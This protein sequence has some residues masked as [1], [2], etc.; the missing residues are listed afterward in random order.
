MSQ[1]H[2]TC[3]QCSDWLTWR[4]LNAL[5]GCS[6]CSIL[7]HV[8]CVARSHITITSYLWYSKIGSLP[9][10][11]FTSSGNCIARL[12][13]HFIIYGPALRI[14]KLRHSSYYCR[15]LL[16]SWV[17]WFIY[18]SYLVTV[19]TVIAQSVEHRTANSRPVIDSRPCRRTFNF[20]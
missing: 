2:V 13:E 19:H 4:A 20:F 12:A 7:Y 14:S 11:K 9:N 6:V 15:Y 3:T 1:H 16:N 17:P 18:T 5:I 10:R 8:P